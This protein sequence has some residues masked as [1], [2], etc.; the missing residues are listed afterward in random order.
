[1]GKMKLKLTGWFKKRIEGL[2]P[3][4]KF[5]WVKALKLWF[6]TYILVILFK[7]LFIS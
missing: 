7:A 3:K 2:V 5:W 1:M 6:Y 4:G